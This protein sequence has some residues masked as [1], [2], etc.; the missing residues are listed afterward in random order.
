V[1]EDYLPG[2]PTEWT[3]DR[4]CQAKAVPSTFWRV[5]AER[6]AIESEDRPVFGRGL[7]ALVDASVR[8]GNF[9]PR[10]S[11]GW[12]IQV[13]RDGT[14]RRSYSYAADLAVWLLDDPAARRSCRPYNV[15]SDTAVSIAELARQVAAV[16]A[17][18]AEVRI[19]SEPDPTKPGHVTYASVARARD[20][21]GLTAT[22]SLAEAIGRT[23]AWHRDNVNPEICFFWRIRTI[24]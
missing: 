13:P 15:G 12:P 18:G 21:V 14:P 24:V 20:E 5:Y 7:S 2:R 9:I 19:A 1:P 8:V 16:V 6:Y 22:V 4:A 10:R 17:P 11:A 23:A 3:R